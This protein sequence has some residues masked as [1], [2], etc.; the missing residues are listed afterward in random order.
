[1]QL[2]IVTGGSKGIGA[3]L[4]KQIVS[5]GHRAISISRTGVDANSQV[6][7]I[8]HDLKSFAQL[9]EKLGLVLQSLDLSKIEALHLVNNAAVILPV[10]PVNEMTDTEIHQ[11][12]NTNLVTPI[13]LASWFLK[14]FEKY[15]GWKTLT[16]ISSGAASRAIQGWAPYCASKAGLKMFTENLDLDYAHGKMKFL[17]FIPGVVDTD[18]QAVLRAQSSEKF[19]GVHEFQ[20]LKNEGKLRSP[21]SVAQSILKLLLAP[22]KILQVNYDIRLN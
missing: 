5:Q 21:D 10:G 15:P 17:N 20:D 9:P 16:N 14:R 12:L 8:I 1:M 4:L 2:F 22:E 18:M 3:A 13:L 11:H 6:S 7:S 19:S